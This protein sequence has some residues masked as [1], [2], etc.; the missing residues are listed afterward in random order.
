[1]S[2][3]VF[4]SSTSEDLEP[5]RAAARDVV[6]ELGWMPTMME[7]FGA[8]GQGGVVEACSRRVDDSDLVLAILGRP[9][10]PA[11]RWWR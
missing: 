10:A 11:S 6:L 9:S 8:D 7:Y 5:Y 4:I 1:M 2:Q 3:R